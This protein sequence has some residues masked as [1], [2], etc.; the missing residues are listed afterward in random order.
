MAT[1]YSHMI[2]ARNRPWGGKK[3]R[4]EWVLGD[5][6]GLGLAGHLPR[7]CAQSF[8]DIRSKNQWE[9]SSPVTEDQA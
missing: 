4:A 3:L 6:L 7:G 2:H 8:V 9:Q 1:C 5:P